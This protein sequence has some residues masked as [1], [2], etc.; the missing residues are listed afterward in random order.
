MLLRQAGGS[1]QPVQHVPAEGAAGDRGTI[2]V[3]GVVGA[4]RGKA[5][6]PVGGLGGAGPGRLAWCS[7]QASEQS[8]PENCAPPDHSDACGPSRLAPLAFASPGGCSPVGPQLLRGEPV[9]RYGGGCDPNL[10]RSCA[11][12]EH[13]RRGYATGSALESHR[14]ERRRAGLIGRARPS[15]RRAG[16]RRREAART[17]PGGRRGRHRARYADGSP[18]AHAGASACGG[19]GNAHTQRKIAAERVAAVC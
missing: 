8:G 11:G 19:A 4:D 2:E 17:G 10:K 1:L 12:D 13:R 15:T 5:K 6:E 3:A 14:M 16:T 7:G 18:R 9:P